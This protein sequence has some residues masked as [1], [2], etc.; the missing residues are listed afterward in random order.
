[1]LPGAPG[2]LRILL[3][4][5]GA[6]EVRGRACLEYTTVRK[7]PREERHRPQHDK[8]HGNNM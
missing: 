3:R 6:G 5:H 1:M 7:E 4:R 2:R 8:L